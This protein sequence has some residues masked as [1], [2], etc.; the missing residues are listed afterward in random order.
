MGV[1]ARRIDPLQLLLDA[2]K[3]AR[4]A[5]REQIAFDGASAAIE[6]RTRLSEPR[7]EPG[8]ALSLSSGER[9]RIATLLR[10]I[11][12]DPTVQDV[13]LESHVGGSVD[14]AT[15][16]FVEFADLLQMLTD[17]RLRAGTR[18]VSD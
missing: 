15:Q 13:V 11:R 10:A 16:Q 5:T 18:Y 2:A 1:S 12:N 14:A 9:T 17:D 8:A 6:L 7:H 3:A 4:L